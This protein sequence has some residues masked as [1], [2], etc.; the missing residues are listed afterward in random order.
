[1]Q[2]LDFSDIEAYRDVA[3]SHGPAKRDRSKHETITVQAIDLFNVNRPAHEV[4]AEFWAR[5]QAIQDCNL[6]LYEMHT[7]LQVTAVDKVLRCADQVGKLHQEYAAQAVKT[8]LEL[9]QVHDCTV[10]HLEQLRGIQ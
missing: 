3:A 6:L 4:D 1:D 7:R 8:E 9:Q 2:V 5:T 10:K